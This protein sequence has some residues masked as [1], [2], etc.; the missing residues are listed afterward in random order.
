MKQLTLLSLEKR[1]RA[2]E[3]EPIKAEKKEKFDWQKVQHCYSCNKDIPVMIE[4][5]HAHIHHGI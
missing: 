2:L 4:R 3:K 1:V 5:I